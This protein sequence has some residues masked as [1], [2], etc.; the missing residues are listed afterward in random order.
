VKK[1]KGLMKKISAGIIN[2][3]ICGDFKSVETPA[4]LLNKME[5][6]CFSP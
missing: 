1:E 5:T 3:S 4:S 2:Y 6:L